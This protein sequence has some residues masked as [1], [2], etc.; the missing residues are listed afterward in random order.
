LTNCIHW[1]SAPARSKDW[2]VNQRFAHFI[3]DV[4]IGRSTD[5]S[6][7]YTS[8]PYEGWIA[9]D[10]FKGGFRVLTTGGNGFEHTLTFAVN[11]D[12]VV[13]AERARDAGMTA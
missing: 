7:Q 10:P 2:P 13:I 6:S 1:S 12:P 3:G 5:E 11:E 9:A 8:A 4:T